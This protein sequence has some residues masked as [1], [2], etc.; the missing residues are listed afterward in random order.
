VGAR[1]NAPT[2]AGRHTDQRPQTR[3]HDRFVRVCRVRV[4]QVV[5]A[6]TTA[7]RHLINKYRNLEGYFDKTGPDS[8]ADMKYPRPDATLDRRGGDREL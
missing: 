8:D 3:D 5:M 4:R 7:S 1:T 2:G 6:N